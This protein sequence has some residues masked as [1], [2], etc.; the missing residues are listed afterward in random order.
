M[1][2]DYR[3]AHICPELFRRNID[4]VSETGHNGGR[5]QHGIT[6]ILKLC[7]FSLISIS[8][9]ATGGTCPSGANYTTATGNTPV[10]LSSLG[11]TS[12]YYIAANGADTN[13]GVDESHPWLHAPGMPNCA[14][15]CGTVTPSAGQ[16]F[17]LR[18]GDTWHYGNSSAV[19][20]TGIFPPGNGSA[21]DAGNSCGWSIGGP[22]NG[23]S[24]TISNPIY[25][26]VDK[27]WFNAGVCGASWCRPIMNGDNPT[28]N[29]GVGSCTHDE[30]SLSFIKSWTASSNFYIDNFEFTGIC[31]SGANNAPSYIGNGNHFSNSTT[32]RI[33][34]NDYFHGWTHVTFSCSQGPTGNC[35]GGPA[36][37]GPSDST[38]G[39]GDTITDVVVDGSD[40][41]KQS[42][43]GVAFGAYDVHNSVFRYVGNGTTLNN[44]HVWHDNLLEYIFGSSDGVTH[45]NGVEMNT[46]YASVNA[47]YNNVIRNFFVGGVGCGNVVVWRTPQTTDYAFNN[48]LYGQDASCHNANF[49][50][51]VTANQGGA[52]GWTDNEFNNTWVLSANGP[53]TNSTMDGTATVNMINTHCISPNGGTSGANC[54]TIN[55]TINYVS[56]VMQ[57]TTQ[58]SGQ[59][60]T[61]GETFAY[62][63]SSG[64]GATVGA[65][66]NEQNLC[67]ALT[68]SSDPLLRAAGTA[69]QNDTGYA[70][71]YNPSTHSVSCPARTVVARPTSGVWDAGAYEYAGGGGPPAPPSNLQAMPQ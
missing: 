25:F 71:S 56:V 70:C 55:G 45:G 42:F 37:S 47:F 36:I 60:Y 6:I 67:S 52:D 27:T 8:A 20:Y 39:K 12:C 33:I 51:L 69:C 38:A 66:T 59:G 41:D 40:S 54:Q 5:N 34:E 65:G 18:G 14:N 15:T 31:W 58:A 21:C 10:T 1:T 2:P 28:S 29:S 3:R 50:D 48:L 11:V 22:S 61:S 23:W 35:D 30:S 57:T 68:G 43:S 7:M 13:T 64:S 49:W 26:G 9:F 16:G 32:N 62:S 46:E 19:P 53:F 44:N 24:G 63:P 17:I 4:F